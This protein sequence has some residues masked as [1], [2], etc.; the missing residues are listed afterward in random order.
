MSRSLPPEYEQE[1]DLGR[2]RYAKKVQKSNPKAALRFF[3]ELA[4]EGSLLSKIELG[5]CLTHGI[6]TA[7]ND[8]EAEAWFKEA[9]AARSVRGSY[10]LGRFYLR[11]HKYAEA[12]EAYRF[13]AARSYAP[14]LFDLGKIYLLG[15]GVEKDPNLAKRYLL[16]ASEE[17]NVF[18]KKMYA[19]VLMTSA[20]DM[21]Q[22]LR[23]FALQIDAVASLFVT[24][25][26]YGLNSDRLFY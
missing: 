5:R 19:R 16:Q 3:R 6:G 13:S 10:F 20:G 26:K 8:A 12:R 9:A 23:G 18:A 22:R 15:L 11:I 2:W 24:I 1:V 25:F 7:R 21:K 14:A 4:G 17:G